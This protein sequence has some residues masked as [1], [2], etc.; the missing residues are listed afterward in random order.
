M[1][2]SVLSM[3]LKWVTTF[4]QNHMLRVFTILGFQDDV[5]SLRVSSV[6]LWY[7]GNYEKS[8]GRVGRGFIF[9][10][11]PYSW[12]P[13]SQEL[14]GGGSWGQVQAQW[15]E[16]MCLTGYVLAWERIGPGN[17]GS[18]CQ[19]GYLARPSRS[20]MVPLGP[21]RYHPIQLSRSSNHH[22]QK[23]DHLNYFYIPTYVHK[24][25]HPFSFQN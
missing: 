24:V 3:S 25:F 9:I 5:G 1:V 19:P 6:I 15:E 11:H 14:W 21:S 16:E 20:L 12:P 7:Y 18:Y 23:V 2:E 22:S 10:S 13:L 17:R 4:L 8:T